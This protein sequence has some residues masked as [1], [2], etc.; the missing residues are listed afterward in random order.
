MPF[1]EKPTDPCTGPLTPSCPIEAGK[2]YQFQA[3]FEVKPFY[4]AVEYRRFAR[5]LPNVRSPNSHFATALFPSNLP[6]F[7][8]RFPYHSLNCV[9]KGDVCRRTSLRRIDIADLL[10]RAPSD[11]CGRCYLSAN[12]VFGKRSPPIRRLTCGECDAPSGAS[13]FTKAIHSCAFS[14]SLSVR[15]DSNSSE[16]LAGHSLWRSGRMCADRRKDTGPEPETE[17]QRQRP[18]RLNAD[19]SVLQTTKRSFSTH[20]FD[21]HGDEVRDSMSGPL[22]AHVS[23]QNAPINVTCRVYCHRVVC[24]LKQPFAPPCNYRF[25]CFERHSSRALK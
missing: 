8:S 14:F 1:P 17:R 11:E 18:Q 16:V 13:Q 2:D 19:R 21:I 22:T 5:R 12:C 3:S 4:P 20:R 25:E 15:T 23:P 7:T 10:A 6:N 9:F 24:K